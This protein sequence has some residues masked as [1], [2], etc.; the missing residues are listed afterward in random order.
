M[1]EVQNQLPD[2]KLVNLELYIVAKEY[3]IIK[4]VIC[5]DFIISIALTKLSVS[6][7]LM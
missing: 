7:M 2:V 5:V 4:K 6:F 1:S 3:N